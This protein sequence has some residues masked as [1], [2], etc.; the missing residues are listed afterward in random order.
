M[1]NNNLNIIK[2]ILKGKVYLLFPFLLIIL[3]NC[4]A[5]NTSKAQSHSDTVI[6]KI[7]P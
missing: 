6:T 2:N 3:I 1:L 7:D 5:I 4:I